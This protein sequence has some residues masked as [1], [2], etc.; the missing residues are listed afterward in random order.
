[1][2]IKQWGNIWEDKIK[3]QN[4]VQIVHGSNS[5]IKK[6]KK[7]LDTDKRNFKK[8]LFPLLSSSSK[9]LDCGVGPMA[10]YAILFSKEGYD[11]TG[12]DISKTTIR[13]ARAHAKNECQDI[14]FIESNLIDLSN[15]RNN[16]FD[17]VFCTQTFGH[18]PSYLAL[19]VLKEFAKKTRKNKYCLVQFWIE[20]EPSVKQILTY[21]LYRLAHK[22]KKRIKK[23]YYINC[24]TY[25]HEEI[26]DMI[27]RSGFELVKQFGGFYLMQKK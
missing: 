8:N 12:V 15:L 20:E 6:V 18:I 27:D 9:I 13:H 7:E 1:M 4:E 25:S 26:L 11:V 24:S 2:G 21:S 10:R 17:L 3:N 5:S 22:I 14:K 23:S 19:N 16:Y